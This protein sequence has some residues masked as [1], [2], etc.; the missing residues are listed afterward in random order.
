MFPPLTFFAERSQPYHSL[1]CFLIRRNPSPLFR[2]SIVITVLCFLLK[3]FHFHSLQSET[4]TLTAIR[5]LIDTQDC[6]CLSSS[7][8]VY[9]SVSICMFVF[10]LLIANNCMCLPEALRLIC[11][12]CVQYLFRTVTDG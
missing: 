7:R 11:I 12:L 5:L 8:Y 4:V 2:S 9:L 6:T 1:E 10:H 3:K